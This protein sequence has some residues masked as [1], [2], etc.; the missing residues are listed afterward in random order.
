VSNGDP[1]DGTELR[2][3]GSSVGIFMILEVMDVVVMC[4][5][6]RWENREDGG[7]EREAA[8]AAAVAEDAAAVAVDARGGR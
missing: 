1:K 2:P 5:G 8:A 6:P 7:D 4:I 3:K